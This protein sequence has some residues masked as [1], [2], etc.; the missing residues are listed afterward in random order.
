MTDSSSVGI[1]Q[2]ETG[3]PAAVMQ[4][5]WAALALA[6]SSMPNHWLCWQMR[7]RTSVEKRYGIFNVVI[8]A[9][10]LQL[11]SSKSRD[12]YGQLNLQIV[13]KFNVLTMDFSELIPIVD[14]KGNENPNHDQK[15]LPNRIP[16]ILKE[17]VVFGELFSDSIKEAWHG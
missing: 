5:W 9:L 2:A 15:D 10:I 16:R 1:T 17:L 8:Y 12:V 3:E 6:S 13:Q 11:S 7:W 14:L 4:G